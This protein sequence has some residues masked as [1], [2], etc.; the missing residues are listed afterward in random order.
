[1]V[2]ALHNPK[3]NQAEMDEHITQK[4]RK[5]EKYLNLEQFVRKKCCEIIHQMRLQFVVRI[6]CIFYAWRA[7]NSFGSS[8]TLNGQTLN[9][10]TA[11]AVLLK[12]YRV[13]NTAWGSDLSWSEII[14]NCYEFLLLMRLKLIINLL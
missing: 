4:P 14:K 6:V 1:M 7:C 2:I 5:A 9:Q 10:N 11:P 13:A 8:E 12:L 3:K